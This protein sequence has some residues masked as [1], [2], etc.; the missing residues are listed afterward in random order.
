MFEFDELEEAW[1][2]EAYVVFGAGSKEMNGLYLD[3]QVEA[4]GAPIFRHTLMSSNLLSRELAGERHGWLLGANRRPFYG[5]RTE[6]LKCPSSGWRTGRGENPAPS[7]ES[8]T[9]VAEATAKLRQLWCQ[10]G[11]KL[12]AEGK[13][14]QAADSYK[15]ALGVPDSTPKEQA[16]MHS[17]RAGSFRQLAESKKGI[18]SN[19]ECG[20]GLNPNEEPPDPLLGLAAEWAI[21]EAEKALNLDEKCFLAGWEGAMAA[22]HIGWWTKGRLLAKKAM[23]SVP[24]GPAHRAQRETANTLFILLAEQEQEEKARKVRESQQVKVSPEIHLD[25][26]ELEWARA[27]IPQ[28]NEALKAEDFRR[29]H[30]QL[31]KLVGPGL[32]KKDTDEIFG[33]IRNLVW[34][35]WNSIA[36]LHGYRTSWDVKARQKMCSR[37]VNV[38]NTGKADDVKNLIKEMEDRICLDWPEI[39]EAVDRVQ[40]DE[41]WAWGRR[42]DGTWGTWGSST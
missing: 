8:F 34:E 25:P 37:L 29:P 35:K 30:H 28:L 32:L 39:P 26:N 24:Q 41:T 1:A 6:E 11:E 40:H 17:W 10:E 42:P 13:F 19:A 20:G 31:W 21:E 4:F 22:K 27:V 2:P 3:M 36:W 15:L 7:V 5:V 23:Q 16:E 12:N 18:A 33:E 14:R 9:T 38:A